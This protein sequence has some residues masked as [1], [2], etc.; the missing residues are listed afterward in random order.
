MRGA[1][2]R[3]LKVYG[4]SDPE[5]LKLFH[6]ANQ[7]EFANVYDIHDYGTLT[8]W[9]RRIKA[10]KEGLKYLG[11]IRLGRVPDRR[12]ICNISVRNRETRLE[13]E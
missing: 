2:V 9:K 7:S 11:N 12:N 13:Y 4:V 3:T 1:S 10:E 6:I 5:D 8:R